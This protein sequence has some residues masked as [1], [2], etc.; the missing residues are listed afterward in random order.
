M[1]TTDTSP[2]TFANVTYDLNSSYVD[3]DG[4]V[5]FFEDTIS[6]E[7]GT[8]EMRSSADCEAYSLADVI[9]W[10][11]PLK[12]YGRRPTT[13]PAQPLSSEDHDHE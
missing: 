1:A 13:S 11:G 10:W 6:A 7:D 12:A 2:A 5:W 4:D 8:W 9:L 3:R